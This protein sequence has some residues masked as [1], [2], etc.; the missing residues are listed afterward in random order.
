ME[1]YIFFY[2]QNNENKVMNIRLPIGTEPSV[3]TWSGLFQGFN[4]EL[5]RVATYEELTR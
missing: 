3:E 5:L 2:K 4:A 1:N